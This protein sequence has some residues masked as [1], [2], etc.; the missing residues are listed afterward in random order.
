MND[1]LE[2]PP[3]T[4]SSE[5]MARAISASDLIEKLNERCRKAWQSGGSA[6]PPALGWI[7]LDEVRDQRS[8]IGFSGLEQLMQSI[9]ERCRMQLDTGDLSARFGLDAIAVMLDPARGERDLE[10]T[11]R[12]VI[13]AINSNLFEIGEL[14]IAATVSMAIRP[15]REALKPAEANLVRAA[16]AAELISDQGGNRFELG[17]RE[18]T[19][20]DAPGALLGQLT[21]AIRDNTIRVVSQP[22]MSTTNPARERYQLFPRLVAADGSLIPA[23]RFVPIAA[24]RGA[25][26]ALDH[27]MVRY[28]VDLLVKRVKAGQELPRLFLSQSTAL[29][30]DSRMLSQLRDKLQELE[31]DQRLLVLEF[32]IL[33]LKPRIREAR[34]TFMQLKELGTRI[35]ISGIDEK[36]PDAV[37]L[38]HLP[39]D[40][41]KMKSNFAQ[42]VLEDKA[43]SGRFNDFADQARKAGRQVIVPML[44]DAESVSRF[45]QMNVDLIQGNFIHQ[46]TE[47]TLG[48]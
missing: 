29:I 14:S 9:H 38:R 45:W 46:P 22:F 48:A 40:Y 33:E 24:E 1:M 35:S 28:A 44:E 37:L 31:P 17:H 16:A 42:R 2:A 30:E 23:A 15:V 25:L 26:P 11:A 36:V 18:V 47:E 4:V 6:F 20:A 32:S 43:L 5:T 7:A 13:K 41:L 8:Q 21:R 27:W 10:R 3:E 19:E 34:R 39:A 12:D